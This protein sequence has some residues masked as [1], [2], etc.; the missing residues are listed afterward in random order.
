M[1]M[2]KPSGA[3]FLKP[4]LHRVPSGGMT[5][6]GH[7]ILYKDSPSADW[8][9]WKTF[10]AE[11]YRDRVFAKDLIAHPGY[12]LVRQSFDNPINPTDL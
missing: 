8:L 3:Y 11:D 4:P 1:G 9:V 7:R 5:S 6:H 2:H 12:T 10:N